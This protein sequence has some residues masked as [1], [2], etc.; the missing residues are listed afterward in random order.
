M[1]QQLSLTA[2]SATLYGPGAFY[3]YPWKPLGQVTRSGSPFEF[4]GCSL[5]SELRRRTADVRLENL[6]NKFLL[7]LKTQEIP[8][9]L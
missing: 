5:V 2:S 1:G 3:F 7:V 9:A 8:A 4:P 6:R